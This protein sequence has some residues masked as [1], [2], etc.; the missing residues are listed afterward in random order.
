MHHAANGLPAP[1]LGNQHS[2]SPVWEVFQFY[3]NHLF[4]LATIL[5]TQKYLQLE[6]L[7]L[8]IH[9]LTI[10]QLISCPDRV[11]STRAL[12]AFIAKYSPNT[13][14]SLSKQLHQDTQF[15]SNAPSYVTPFH[16]LK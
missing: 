9:V 16:H 4:F 7:G 12:Y 2:I 1:Q 15:C 14:A 10:K 8:T 5:T 13:A 6:S 11:S 3:F